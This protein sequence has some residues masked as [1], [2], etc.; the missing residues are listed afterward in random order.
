ML[1]LRTVAAIFISRHQGAA[2]STRFALR[3]RI[4]G[5]SIIVGD[6]AIFTVRYLQSIRIKI[7]RIRRRV[8]LRRVDIRY[9]I[10][11]NTLPAEI[12]YISTVWF[13]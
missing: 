8:K 13:Q 12:V 4:R 1:A 10:K 6:I 11:S 9:G 2:P 7:K 5:M 3:E